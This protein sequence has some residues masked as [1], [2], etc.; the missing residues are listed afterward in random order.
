[1]LL[2][3]GNNSSNKPSISWLVLSS[4]DILVSFK[5]LGDTDTCKRQLDK[6]NTRT[7]ASTIV[8]LR[9]KDQFHERHISY[10]LE[11]NSQANPSI[12][13]KKG[14]QNYA[15]PCICFVF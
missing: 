14:L 1:M 5:R 9:T 4:D 2:G 12:G 11:N 13:N 7:I 6:T 3:K 15:T 8:R 10:F